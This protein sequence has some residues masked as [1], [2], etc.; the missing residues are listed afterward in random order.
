MNE[1]RFCDLTVGMEEEF[2][3]EITLDMV[4]DFCRLTG[5]INPLHMDGEYARER[6]FSDRVVYGMLTASFVSMLGETVR[7]LG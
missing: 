5:D 2:Q 4:N 7:K 1:Y 3:K 6:G